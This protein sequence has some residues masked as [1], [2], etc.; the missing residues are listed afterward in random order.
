VDGWLSS[1]PDSVLG[2]SRRVIVLALFALTAAG[3]IYVI[4]ERP[5]L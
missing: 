3:V 1:R 2:V 5:M 4:L